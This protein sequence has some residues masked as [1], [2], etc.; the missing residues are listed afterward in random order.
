MC[1]MQITQALA[2]AGTGQS[3][4]CGSEFDP[5]LAQSLIRHRARSQAR[6]PACVERGGPAGLTLAPTGANLAD[7]R[8]LP[9]ADEKGGA[10]A[11]EVGGVTLALGGV[12]SGDA[13]ARRLLTFAL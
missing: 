6:R 2:A 11:G 12:R 7:E 5:P 9:A 13:V 1:Q 3:L 8:W 10:G 4:S